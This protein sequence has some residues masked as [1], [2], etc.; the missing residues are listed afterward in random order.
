MQN[1]MPNLWTLG[2]LS[3]PELLR[4]TVFESWRDDVFGQGGRMAFYQFLAIFPSLLIAFTLV[5]HIPH[6]T[7]H[8]RTSLHDLSA[9]LFPNRVAQLFDRIVADFRQRPRFGLRLLSVCAAAVWAAHNGTWAM[10]WG[11][12]RA[13]E[14]QERRSWWN[15]TVTIVLLTLCLA[16]IACAALLL[17]FSSAFLQQHVH[18][19][20]GLLRTLE[21]LSVAVC[22]YFAFAFLYRFA[23]NV[24]D[25]AIRWST[26]GALCAL[27]LWL[28]STFAAH[29]YFDHINDYT[30]SYGPLNSVVMLLLWLYASNGA[31]LIGGEMNSE[32]QKAEAGR[33]RS[34]SDASTDL[35]PARRSWPSN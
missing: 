26:P 27:I 17:L 14:V 24:P 23:P 7:A 20:T 1:R 8:L 10:I 6:L 19:G 21:W 31:L 22:L 15:L 11:L 2:G 16:V 9:Q 5:T 35:R 30:R 33:S 32:I 28:A 18:G 4:R 13:Y 29:I 25:H 34:G 12:N 3:L